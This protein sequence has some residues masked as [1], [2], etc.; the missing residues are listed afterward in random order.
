MSTSSWMPS[1]RADRSASWRARDR[2][3]LWHPFTQH[4]AWDEEEF[5]VIERARGSWLIDVDGRRYLDG[6]SSMW[7][8]NVGHANPHVTRA[9]AR[10]L[11]R[12]E[13]ATFLGLTHPA[14]IEY[15]EKLLAIAPRNLSR[16]FYSDNGSTAV[17]IALKMAVQFWAQSGRPTRR[18][19][20]ALA[21]AYH[22]DT[23]GAM[24]VGGVDVFLERYRSLLFPTVLSPAPY[25][26]R[27]TGAPSLEECGRQCLERLDAAVKAQADE[28]AGVV[29]EPVVQGAGGM[30]VQPPGFVK[31]VE[32]ICRKHD[33]LFIL[34]EVMTGF[35]RT[36]TM[37]ACEQDDARPDLMAVSKGMAGGYLPFAAT[38]ATERIFRAFLGGV[39]ERKVLYHG[40]TYTGN[41]LGCAAGL[42]VLEAFAGQ[43]V[44]ERLP[45]RIEA[46]RKGLAPL[47][48][49]P[50]VGEIRQRGLVAGIELVKDRRTREEFP[51]ARRTGHRVALECRKRGVILRPLADV[52][53]VM[54]PLTTTAEEIRTLTR[55]V[56]EAV[57]SVFTSG[58]GR[59]R[60]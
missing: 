51:Y 42:G 55:V 27:W 52:L 24:S 25:A 57:R 53:V 43:R 40:H 17:E 5:P 60:P 14:A 33:V 44:M 2:K 3:V 30:I 13:H 15:A 34:D 23:V 59:M 8:A 22:G 50:N 46:L 19:F 10:Q 29:T 32:E 16:V 6:V 9:V 56:R 39:E 26:Y 1:K 11:K 36:G 37:F 28:V 47:A 4:A 18:R 12:L 20:V 48:G 41:P 45:E 7:C 35:G 21:G 49:H 54:P 58:A 31:G 38:L